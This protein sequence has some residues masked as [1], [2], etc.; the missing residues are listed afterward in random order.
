MAIDKGKSLIFVFK[1]ISFMDISHTYLIN[2]SQVDPE[3]LPGFQLSKP[4]LRHLLSR[5]I[6]LVTKNM[7]LYR[8]WFEAVAEF[9]V[10][11]DHEIPDRLTRMVGVAQ[12]YVSK[13][14]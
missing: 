1:F 13:N 4:T 5:L 2:I 14:A 6:R 8:S 9:V 10:S 11:T 3:G 7:G 12:A